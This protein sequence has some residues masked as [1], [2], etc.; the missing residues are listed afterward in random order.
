M[1]AP[2][3]WARPGGLGTLLSPLG[4]LYALGGR[5]RR[6]IARPYKAGLPVICVGNLTMGGAGKT[7]VVQAL[8]RYLQSLNKKPAILLR[9]Y[10]GTEA[11]PLL[12]DPALHTAGQVGDEA[13]LHAGLAPTIVAHDRAL[14]ARMAEKSGADIIVMD[15][16]FQN[17]GLYQDAGLI[18]ADGASG[19]GNGLVFPAGPLRE[20]LADGIGRAKAAIVVGQDEYGISR[21]LHPLPVFTARME[22]EDE[23][24]R[25]KDRNVVAFA[26]IGRP[27]KFFATLSSLGAKLAMAFPFPD[28]HGFTDCE[29]EA[30]LEQAKDLN[31]LLVTTAKDHVRLPKDIQPKVEVLKV[32]LA[33]D[34][35]QA[36]ATIL[37]DY[38]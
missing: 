31:A 37:K 8:V 6:A 5:L 26:G 3:F 38:I 23:A 24:T 30:L 11:G 2:E 9:G 12:V 34:D 28:H 16:G 19:F 33:W 4:G 1:R 13:L 18:V 15:D 7:P 29:I 36:P 27:E 14:G 32:S 20:P 22:P 25:F 17:P 35:A 10:K 21:R